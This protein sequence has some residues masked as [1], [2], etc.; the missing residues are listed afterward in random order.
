MSSDEIFATLRSSE[1]EMIAREK[2]RAL[3]RSC[4]VEPASEDLFRR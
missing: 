3:A 2:I 1:K 4:K